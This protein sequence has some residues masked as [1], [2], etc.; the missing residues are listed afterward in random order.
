MERRDEFADYL[1]SEFKS[2]DDEFVEKEAEEILSNN[3]AGATREDRAENLLR[4]SRIIKYITYLSYG[5]AIWGFLYP[6]PYD[7]LIL[8]AVFF[9][10]IAFILPR[11]YPGVVRF[12][13]RN[14]SSYP[15]SGRIVIIPSLILALRAFLDWE[16]F[17]WTSFWPPFAAILF[18][19]TLLL[20]LSYP[21]ERKASWN[22]IFYFVLLGIYAYGSTI[23]LNGS[24]DESDPTKVYDVTV[25]SKRISSG[26]HTT[27]YLEITPWGP[28]TEPEEVS[29]PKNLYESMNASDQAIVHIHPGRLNIPWF[30]IKKADK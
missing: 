8:V 3:E 6:H 11:F 27:Y 19:M 26:K 20:F 21:E 25:V 2:L 15:A 12:D 14:F 13:S 16:I 7:V 30:H 4:A 22:T 28:R 23:S 17:N 5:I 18:T 10:G 1:F 29:V 9:P 24:L